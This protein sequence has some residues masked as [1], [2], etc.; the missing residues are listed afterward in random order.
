M[1]STFWPWSAVTLISIITNITPAYY[2]MFYSE[3]FIL[4]LQVVEMF[5]RFSSPFVPQPS[6][7]QAINQSMNVLN[8]NYSMFSEWKPSHMY[9]QQWGM[10]FGLWVEL[11]TWSASPI[12]PLIAGMFSIVEPL[13]HYHWV[14]ISQ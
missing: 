3:N 7:S 5:T 12:L 2:F 13:E 10:L 6:L 4:M 11:H 1:L 8:H 9:S 14:S